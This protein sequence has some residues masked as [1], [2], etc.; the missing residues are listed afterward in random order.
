MRRR[1]Y[2]CKQ[3]HDA[4]SLGLVKSPKYCRFCFPKTT[5][6][7]SSNQN[8]QLDHKPNSL[9]PTVPKIPAL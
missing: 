1:K 7:C 6:W 4:Q 5:I 2:Q 9:S 3:T 8:L